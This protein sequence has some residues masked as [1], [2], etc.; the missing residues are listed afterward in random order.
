M[1]HALVIYVP[2]S[3]ISKPH[4]QEDGLINDFCDGSL[5]KAHPLFNEEPQALQIIAYYDDVEVCNP[6]GSHRGINKLGK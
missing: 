3:Q 5:F 6:L 4:Q 2:S 1:I